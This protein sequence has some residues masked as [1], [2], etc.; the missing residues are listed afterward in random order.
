MYAIRSYYD[1][2][3]L[4]LKLDDQVTERSDKNP[5][6]ELDIPGISGG[7]QTGLDDILACIEKA[8][9]DD[10][11]RGI[12]LNPSEIAAGLA[13]IEEIRN[14]LADFKESGKFVYAYGEVWSQKA[15]YLVSVADKVVLNPKGM[16][17]FKGLSA[18]RN[19][20]KKALEKL[21]VEVQVI[22]HGKFKAAVE[23]FML[24]KMSPENRLQTETYLGSIWN[25]MLM[26]I[27]ASRGLSLDEL[28]D[29][30]IT[31]YNVCY[32]KLLRV[33]RWPG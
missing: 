6:R 28:N 2:S 32:T 22:R 21:G 11:I 30:R 12:Y 14:A 33:E 24:E 15:F 13:T 25:Q 17:D 1:K 29:F 16:I 19:F 3:L 4:I 9:T 23:P 26:D 27:S 18:Q 8:K 10:R 20:Y 31:S 5:F 7:R